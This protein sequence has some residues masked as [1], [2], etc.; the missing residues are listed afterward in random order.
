MGAR[1]PVLDL[2]SKSDLEGWGRDFSWV[3]ERAR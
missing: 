2:M 1:R 3:S